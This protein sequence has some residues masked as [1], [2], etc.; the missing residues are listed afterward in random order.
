MRFE[1]LK[2][3]KKILLFTV[4][5]FVVVLTLIITTSL[6]KYKITESINIA[7]G[8]INYSPSDLSIMGIYLDGD[9]GY[10]QSDTVPE[11]GY[12]LNSEESYCSVNGENDGTVSI[13]YKNGI[14]YIGVR[15][16]NTKCYL[17]FDEQPISVESILAEMTKST[18]TDFSTVLTTST[19][20]TVYSVE[21]DDGTSYYYAGAPTDNWVKFAGFYWRIIRFNGDGSIRLIYNGTTTSTTG[22]ETQLSSPSKFNSSYNNNAYVGLKYTTGSL[23]GTGTKSTILG[24]LESFYTSSLSSYASYLDT[25]AGFCGDRTPSTSSS[26]SNGSGGT[27]T[28]GTYYGAYIRLKTNKAP[29]LTCANSSDLYTT[30]SSSKGNKALTYPVGLITADEVAYAGGVYGTDNTGYYLYTNKYYWTL[31]P[32]RFSSATDTAYVFYV[33]STG[34]LDY[35]NVDNTNGVRPVINLKTGTLFT[36]GTTGTASNPYEVIMN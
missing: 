5:S 7:S 29:V 20:K 9:N 36:A 33:T 23:R 10:T 27:G 18:R 34:N 16:K 24:A 6:A 25:N 11:S 14:V 13:E 22:T 26:S 15:K 8:I 28:T 19:T 30:S 2:D 21:D 31:S 3:N 17:Y 12:I 1:T 35:S 4:I 32:Y